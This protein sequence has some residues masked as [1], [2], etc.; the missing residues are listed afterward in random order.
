MRTSIIVRTYNESEHLPALLDRCRGLRAADSQVEVIVV[1]SGSTDDTVAIARRAGAQV[2][3]I[4]KDDFTFG[5]SLNLGCAAARGRYLAFI[6][7]HC[8]PVND[9]WLDRLLQPLEAEAAHYSYGRQ[10]GDARSRFSERQLFGKYYPDASRVPQAGY[11]CNNANAAMPRAVW[12]DQPFDEGL[13]GLEDMELAQRLVAQ[14]RRIA[15]VAEAPVLHLHHESW[16]KVRMRFE[17]EAIALQRIMPH[18]HVSHLDFVRYFATAVALDLRAAWR[19]GELA[20]RAGEIVMFRLMQYWGT[21]RGNR[22]HRRLS[23]QAKEE[24]FYPK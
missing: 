22:E 1:D 23:A 12:Q 11:F 10:L 4:A 2:L 14:G 18:V 21:F 19:E 6:S 16:H 8:L 3:H 20:A 9:D 13:T 7:G 24:Y 5:R 15:Y 17:R